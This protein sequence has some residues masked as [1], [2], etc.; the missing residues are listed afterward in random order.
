MN[1]ITQNY[2]GG[3]L[4]QSVR[5]ERREESKGEPS[6][7]LT[8]KLQRLL[9]QRSQPEKD[10]TSMNIYKREETLRLTQR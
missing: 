2:L 6:A 10:Y 5:E 3:H 9:K 8:E 7:G 1:Q 4:P